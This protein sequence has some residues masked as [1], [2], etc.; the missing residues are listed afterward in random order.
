MSRYL[1]DT[2]ALVAAVSS[3][4]EHH[5]RTCA[6]M[7]R[8]KRGKEELVISAHSLA[9]TYAVLTRLPAPHRLRATDA[10]ALIESNWARHA[11]RATDRRRDVERTAGSAAARHDRRADVRRAHRAGRAEGRSL[12]DH[13]LERTPLRSVR[14]EHRRAGSGI[15]G[16]LH[17]I[18]RSHGM[19]GP[20]GE[21]DS[22]G[23]P[24]E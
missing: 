6:E 13:H 7:E 18:G 8:R 17:G 16:S 5:D 15:G 14:T 4:H 23:L 2:S 19:I 20:S 21:N 24:S 22:V 9:E 1:C 10:I 11:D 12:H 3:W